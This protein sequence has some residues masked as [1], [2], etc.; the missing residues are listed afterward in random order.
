MYWELSLVKKI[1]ESINIPSPDKIIKP[2]AIQSKE[3][4]IPLLFL[5]KRIP[6]KAK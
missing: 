3:V 6:T 5:A 4:A 1:A 2:T